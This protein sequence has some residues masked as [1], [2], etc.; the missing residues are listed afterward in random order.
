MV[1]KEA[2]DENNPSGKKD[3]MEHRCGLEDLDEK[4]SQTEQS[5]V[6]LK[7]GGGVCLQIILGI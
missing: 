5:L 7:W 2:T 6:L 3:V 4:A 1:S